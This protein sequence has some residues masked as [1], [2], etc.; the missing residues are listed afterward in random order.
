MKIKNTLLSILAAGL[1]LTGCNTKTED[2]KPTPVVD[3]DDDYVVIKDGDVDEFYSGSVGGTLIEISADRYLEENKQYT[4]SL[5]VSEN[6]NKSLTFKSKYETVATLEAATTEGA[7]Y[8]NT[9]KQGDTIIYAY[10]CDGAMVLRQ[11]VRVRKTIE[12]SKMGEH[13]FTVDKWSS[14]GML[15]H[16]TLS[17][18]NINPI[19]GSLNGYD[20]F[21]TTSIVFN[22]INPKQVDFYDFTF[23]TYEF[24]LDMEQY[25]SQ[26]SY[27][28]CYVSVTGDQILIYYSSG[29]EPSLL[30]MFTPKVDK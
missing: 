30:E 8:I 15:G 12:M 25:Q 19:T 26:R 27:V 18:V 17:F 20:D 7:F 14:T 9:H 11:I 10:D 13:L 5:V 6:L 1:L 4:C 2:P 16:Y 28:S 22:L 21:E 3:D 23:Y 29:S 24:E